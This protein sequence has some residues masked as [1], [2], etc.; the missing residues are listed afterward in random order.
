MLSRPEIAP[1]N[2]PEALPAAGKAKGFARS[3]LI[4]AA[5]GL[6]LLAYNLAPILFGI[7]VLLARVPDDAFYYL[8]LA[9]NFVTTGLWTF[10][11]AHAAT[12]FHILYGY[13]LALMYAVV[14][15]IGLVPAYVLVCVFNAALLAG[16]V[17]LLLMTA[18]NLGFSAGRIGVILVALSPAS[19]RLAGYPMETCLAV[20]FSSA[21]MLLVTH[22]GSRM[23]GAMFAAFAVGILGVLSR[24][25]FGALPFALFAGA[26]AYSYFKYR[27]G[28]PADWRLLHIAAVLCVGAIAGE[29]LVMLHTHH[30]TGGFVQ[31]SASIKLH[32]AQVSGYNPLPGVARITE[33]AGPHIIPR[34]IILALIA[35][36]AVAVVVTRRTEAVLANPIVPGAILIM[37]GY[38]AVYMLNGAVQYWYAGLYFAAVAMVSAAVWQSFGGASTR[39]A[40]GAIAIFLAS[41]VYQQV[42]PPWPWAKASRE[43]GDYIRSHPE[44]GRVGSWNAGITAFYAGRPVV[45][46]DGLVNDDV[47]AAVA[48]NR[49]ANYL[50]DRDIRYVVDFTSMLDTE[51]GRR[52]GYSDGTLAR[53]V[54]PERTFG[55]D[56]DF[57]GHKYTLMSVDHACIRGTAANA[58]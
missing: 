52:G 18:D 38:C 53:C 50:V 33:L 45:N 24:S 11:G 49:L 13:T 41:A 6:V 7:D 44:L 48:G 36:V 5:I 14:P 9:R 17:Y 2:P 37:A 3:G 31:R 26:A 28:T 15:D 20:F 54:K 43:A 57:N 10:D 4:A 21:A 55:A 39:V 12:G 34:P 42:N 51:G 47:Y 35:L 32:W 40:A 56:V 30:F 22:A 23:K 8:I 46:L 19:F 27:S 58:P 25:D 1:A 29:V 16:S